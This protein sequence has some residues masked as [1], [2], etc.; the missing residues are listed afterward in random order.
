MEEEAVQRREKRMEE[1]GAEALPG[2][3]ESPEKPHAS[4]KDHSSIPLGEE[5]KS[6]PLRRGEGTAFFQEE[7]LGGAGMQKTGTRSF[8]PPRSCTSFTLPSE[9]ATKP[10]K[11][12]EKKFIV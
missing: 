4:E 12:K 6:L 11:L 1:G 9:P 8:P 2:R 3:E 7:R 5:E 10:G